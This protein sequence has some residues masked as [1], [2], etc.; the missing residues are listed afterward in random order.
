MN[1]INNIYSL[2]LF[3]KKKQI[4][5]YTSIHKDNIIT[6]KLKKKN[7][8]P[9]TLKSMKQNYWMIIAVIFNWIVFF[10]KRL[11]AKKEKRK[12]WKRNELALVIVCSYIQKSVREK[13]C[14]FPPKQNP[15]YKIEK[16]ENNQNVLKLANEWFSI[17]CCE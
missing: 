2:R 4:H 1:Q 11:I 9:R 5:T 10:F 12:Q 3:K 14:F 7:H 15:E 13:V 8:Q 6:R 16:A 17:K